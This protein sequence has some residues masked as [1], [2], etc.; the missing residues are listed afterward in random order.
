[1]GM[2]ENFAEQRFQ[3]LVVAWLETLPA[4]GW[5]GT[6]KE[7]GNAIAASRTVRA[8]V[9]M[10]GALAIRDLFPAI[11][12]AGWIVSH[13]RTATARLIRFTRNPVPDPTK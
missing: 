10:S 11:Q 6:S 8:Y 13:E 12:A 9:P 5:R 3:A 4:T 2:R 7:L 1:M